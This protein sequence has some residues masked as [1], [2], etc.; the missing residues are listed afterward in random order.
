[1]LYERNLPKYYRVEAYRTAAYL[2]DRAPTRGIG[3]AL[4]VDI[5]KGR[6]I[7]LSHHRVYC[8][9]SR[10]AAKEAGCYLLRNIILSDFGRIQ[11]DIL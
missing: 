9:W 4:P 2:K 3:N 6:M 1:M 8:Q 5:W 11:K 10:G 7:N